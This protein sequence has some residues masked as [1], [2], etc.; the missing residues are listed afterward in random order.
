MRRYPLA[1][2]FAVSIA[3]V[4]RTSYGSSITM[5]GGAGSEPFTTFSF[6]VD[7]DSRGANCVNNPGCVF[8]NETGVT[9]TE[10]DF[11]YDMPLSS[12]G[13]EI[14]IGSPFS[15][16]ESVATSTQV[17]FEFF[18]GALRNG[19]DFGL[20]FR[21]PFPPNTTLSATATAAPEPG[22]AALLLIS[23]T[24]IMIAS[25]RVRAAAGP[26]PECKGT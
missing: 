19:G 10:I 1:L 7:L 18:G 13:C 21:D 4:P 17:T 5:G 23:L 16:C 3:V 24:G 12:F 8:Q 20:S 15:V 14:A 11:V 26:V 25:R 6:S 9:V 2:V 22:S